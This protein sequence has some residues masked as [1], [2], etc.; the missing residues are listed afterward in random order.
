MKITLKALLASAII[1]FAHLFCSYCVLIA[2]HEVPK[3]PER[4]LIRHHCLPGYKCPQYAILGHRTAD[5]QCV[6]HGEKC[7][8]KPWHER[9]IGHYKMVNGT[10]TCVPMR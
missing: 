6:R 5:R 2:K 4:C 10:M 9:G 7:N 1:T 3:E 8:L